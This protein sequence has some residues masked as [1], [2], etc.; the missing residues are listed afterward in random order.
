MH[1]RS[2]LWIS[3]RL[4][5]MI[6]C[7]IFMGL[8]SSSALAEGNCPPGFYPIGGQGAQGCAPIPGAAGRAS[9]QQLPMPP[10]R[11]SGQWHKTWGAVAMGEQGDTGVSKQKS[12]R[13]EA[14]SE[15]LAQ[16][17]TWGAKRCVVKISYEN[18]C[19]A[20]ASPQASQTGAHIARA[21]DTDTAAQVA[22]RGC[23]DQGGIQCKVVYSACSEPIFERF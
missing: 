1:F 14:E 13:R 15:A 18:Q 11:P 8:A 3:G 19:V 23:K 4:V 6:A 7:V 21:V 9:S 16:C 2:Q 20:V 22:M 10:P 12:S 5:M 17:A